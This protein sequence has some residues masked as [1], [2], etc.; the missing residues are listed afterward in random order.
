MA[1]MPIDSCSIQETEKKIEKKNWE[2]K[3]ER[4]KQI[5]K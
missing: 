5:R 2:R 4:N 3:K 1:Y